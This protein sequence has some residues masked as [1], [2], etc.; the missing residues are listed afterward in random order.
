MIRHNKITWE[1]TYEK[2][3]FC[4]CIDFDALCR[5]NSGYG[6]LTNP[7]TDDYASDGSAISAEVST[8]YTEGMDKVLAEDC[9]DWGR[10]VWREGQSYRR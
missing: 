9:V 4:D 3:V 7:Q 6:S 10:T 1:K 8:E 5:N 2:K